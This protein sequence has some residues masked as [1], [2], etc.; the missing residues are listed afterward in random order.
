MAGL[1]LGKAREGEVRGERG[2]EERLW[3]QSCLCGSILL[4]FSTSTSRRIAIDIQPG[5]R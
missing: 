2:G 4:M 5:V 3:Q 1:H